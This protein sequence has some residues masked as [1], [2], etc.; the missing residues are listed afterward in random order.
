MGSVRRALVAVLLLAAPALVR[1]DEASR[2]K[3]ALALQETVQKVIEKAEPSIACILVSRSDKYGTPPADA[4]AGKLGRFDSRFLPPSA[5]LPDEEQ[6]KNIPSLDMSS[7]DYIPESFGSGVVIDEAGLVLTNA[8]VVRNAT[9][10]FV[11][12]PGG[13]GSW[14]DIHASDPRSDLAVLRLLDRPPGLKALKLGDGEKVKKGQFVVSLSN[15]FAAGFRDGS[16][17]ASWGI[18]S[19]LRRRP[20]G[21]PDEKERGRQ[22]S[23]HANGTLLQTDTRITLG[24]SGGALLNLQG[25]LIGLITSVAALSGSETPGGFAVPMDGGM[26][27]IV[28]KLR[29]GEEVEYGLLG[30]DLRTE[31]TG[32]KG[33]YLKEI[34]HGSPAFHAGLQRGDLIVAIDGIP[35][36]DREDLLL[37]I[38]ARLAGNTVHLDV[39]RPDQPRRVPISVLLAKSYTPGKIIASTKPPARGGLRVDY[40]SVLT[41]REDVP[42]RMLRVIPEGVLIREVVPD[43][44]ADRAHLQKDRIITRVNNQRVNTPAEFYEKMARASRTVE[45]I[46]QSGRGQEERVTL[47]LK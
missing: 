15:P 29:Q 16:P 35:V 17:S 4:A 38:G 24:C 37:L 30:V 42:F 8:H 6:K 11:R 47:D 10:V 44:P 27:R 46:L 19:N 18:V 25:E 26:R 2:L 32:G 22:T 41:Q 12:L 40:T 1:G 13:A 33:V 3:E 20:P 23:I 5:P 39:V 21:N 36:H 45:L 43:S 28:E 7:P 31:D 14:A 9:K 34:T